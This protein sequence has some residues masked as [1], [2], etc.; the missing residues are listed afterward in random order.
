VGEVVS[1]EAKSSRPVSARPAA[2]RTV[3]SKKPPP[4]KGK[5]GLGVKK[6]TTKVDSSVFEQPPME[7]QK[8]TDSGLSAPASS[9]FAYDSLAMGDG[10]EKK[11]DLPRSKDGHVAISDSGDFFS[12]PTG[13]ST[14][15]SGR[16]K[17][18]NQPQ[19]VGPLEDTAQ[20]KFGNAKSIS[21]AMFQEDGVTGSDYDKSARLDRFTGA[22]AISSADYYGRDE[23]ASSGMDASDMFQRLSLQ[24]K[25]DVSN[26]RSAATEA[27]KKLAG[28]ASTFMRDLQSGR[29][30]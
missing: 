29:Y 1:P 14:S 13:R 5:G 28:M 26:M 4:S 22:S 18:D 8:S 11:A 25:Q 7:E 16:S 10:P 23:A 3:L 21:S 17:K 19:A 30:G 27:G 15:T 6:M 24:A 9:R 12:N 2:K 20:K